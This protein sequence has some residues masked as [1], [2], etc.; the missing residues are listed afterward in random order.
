MGFPYN[1]YCHVI[2]NVTI[3]AVII[4][5]VLSSSAW[6]TFPYIPV[7]GVIIISNVILKSIKSDIIK[8][9]IFSAVIIIKVSII[10]YSRFLS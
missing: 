1:R 9:D 10:Q 7:I 2:E 3:G 8:N 5:S 4:I 6:V